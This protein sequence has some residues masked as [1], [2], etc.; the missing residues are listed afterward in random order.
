MAP[1]GKKRRSSRS[2]TRHAR[3]GA[4]AVEALI[5]ISALALFFAWTLYMQ[6]LASAKLDGIYTARR[7]A[8]SASLAGCGAQGGFDLKTALSSFTNHDDTDAT[9]FLSLGKRVSKQATREVKASAPLSASA[10]LTSM[11]VFPCTIV[12]PQHD[13]ISDPTGWVFDLF[14]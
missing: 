6:R 9:G 7:E 10:T 8:W 3:E 1:T 14:M 11:A 5:V 13:P 2:R 12:P 4:V